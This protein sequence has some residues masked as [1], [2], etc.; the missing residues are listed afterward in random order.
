DGRRRPPSGHG[1]PDR[2]RF[3]APAVLPFRRAILPLRRPHPT[4]VGISRI[5]KYICSP[6]RKCP[7]A[8]HVQ[9]GVA[10]RLSLS[11]A[12]NRGFR[13]A[14]RTNCPQRAK[15]EMAHSHP[16]PSRLHGAGSKKAAPAI[17]WPER[18]AQ[19]EP[20]AV[21]RTDRTARF[22]LRHWVFPCFCICAIA[23]F[24]SRETCAWD[25]PISSATSI[26][27]L[28]SKKRID[29]KSVV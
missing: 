11:C 8:L 22:P 5:S 4:A 13:R 6:A 16:P 23:D 15:G 12:K 27:V 14:M 10:D 20:L 9:S 24:S 7:L 29:R 19:R 18:P 25:M 2:R 17:G 26:W 28:P 3:R 21:F 1:A